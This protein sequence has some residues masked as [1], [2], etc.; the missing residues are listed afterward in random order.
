MTAFAPKAHLTAPIWN[1]APFYKSVIEQVQKGT[2]KAESVWPGM[3]TGIVD[4]APS[5]KW[6]PRPCATKS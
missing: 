6:Y 1:W 3:D 4:L 2:W 5:V